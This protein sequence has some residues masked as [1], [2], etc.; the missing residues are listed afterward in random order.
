MDVPEFFAAYRSAFESLD[1]E[2]I[3]PHFAYPVQVAGDTG[4]RIS[5]TTDDR[6]TWERVL[7]HVVDSY[8]V[9]GIASARQLTCDVVTLSPRLHQAAV[10]WGLLAADGATVYEFDA[11]Y[12]LVEADGRLV[13]AAI[14]HNELPQ[15]SAALARPG[16]PEGHEP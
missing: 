7:T 12:T 10:S 9:L 1:A 5:L 14:A 16:V 4:D 15:L 8:R 3:A 11:C 2:A 13:I 6:A